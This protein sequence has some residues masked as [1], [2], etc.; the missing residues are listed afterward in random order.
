MKQEREY[1][2][3]TK[4]DNQVLHPRDHFST[5][6]FDFAN[7]SK[8]VKALPVCITD[9]ISKQQLKIQKG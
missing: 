2:Q 8:T 5:P 3:Q 7:P 9:S 6:F 1:C 4:N